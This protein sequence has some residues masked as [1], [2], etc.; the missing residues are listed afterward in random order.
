MT[1]IRNDTLHWHTHDKLT[2]WMNISRIFPVIFHN[3]FFPLI[4]HLILYPLRFSFFPPFSN[5]IFYV[6]F[7]GL[8]I[9]ERFNLY[10]D[11]MQSYNSPSIQYQAR[12]L[13]FLFLTRH[14]ENLWKN[15]SQKKNE[16][17]CC[18]STTNTR[19]INFWIKY[20][21]H[22]SWRLSNIK[23]IDQ[24]EFNYLIFFS[25]FSDNFLIC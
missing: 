10:V 24:N 7:Q 4:F 2:E 14:M 17:F 25:S 23:G 13:P 1:F 22:W 20:R 8:P 3:I 5:W 18:Y 19:S 9:S 11:D 6:I 21:L 12:V 16:S 15:G